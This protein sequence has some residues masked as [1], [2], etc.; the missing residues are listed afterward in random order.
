MSSSLGSLIPL[1]Q[2]ADKSSKKDDLTGG[3]ISIGTK[4]TSGDDNMDDFDLD[5][6]LSDTPRP[7][8]SPKK[9]KKAKDK[10]KKKKKDKGNDLDESTS[11]GKPPK[12]T[13]THDDDI[14]RP[15]KPKTSMKNLDDEFAK[16]LGFDASE[17]QSSKMDSP[18]KQL[19]QE[20]KPPSPAPSS[21]PTET[22]AIAASFFDEPSDKNKDAG[23]GSW[24]GDRPKGRG[25][26][27]SNDDDVDPFAAKDVKSTSS[28]PFSNPLGRHRDETAATHRGGRANADDSKQPAMASPFARGAADR[29]D[30]DLFNEPPSQT[31]LDKPATNSPSVDDPFATTT[32]GGTG[33]SGRGRRGGADAAQPSAATAGDD[34]P[35]FPWMKAK[36]TLPTEVLDETP[37]QFPW[38]KKKVIEERDQVKPEKPPKPDPK[39]ESD[40]PEFP[41]VKKDRNSTTADTKS[42]EKKEG[43]KPADDDDLPAFPW[44]K[45]TQALANLPPRV[46]EPPPPEPVAAPP[47]L[48]PPKSS[49]EPPVAPPIP[50][51]PI[52]VAEQLASPALSVAKPDSPVRATLQVE[53]QDRSNS[54]LRQPSPVKEPS[55]QRP[56]TPTSKP[57]A[58]QAADSDQ[59]SVDATSSRNSPDKKP[60]SPPRPSIL[61][62]SAVD[63]KAK[64]SNSSPKRTSPSSRASFLNDDASIVPA[65]MTNQ[66]A[67]SQDM[68][69]SLTTQLTAANVAL[70]MLQ[71]DHATVTANLSA[72]SELAKTLTNDVAVLRQTEATLRDDL[73]R[74]GA[75]SAR[76]LEQLN[77]SI[78]DKQALSQE[79]AT[80]RVQAIEVGPLQALVKELQIENSSFRGTLS[81]TQASLAACQRDLVKEQSLHSQSVERFQRMQHEREQEALHQQRWLVEEQRH[82]EKDA[83]ERLLTQVRA[84]VSGLKVLQEN[85]VGGKSELEMRAMGETETRA[86]VLLDME[87]SCKA[88]M[89]R[90]QEECHRLQALL[91][92]MEGTMRTLRGEHL[93][94]KERLR[95]EQS[96]LDE[97]ALHFQSQ[98]TLLQERTDSNT[99]VVTQTLSAYIQDIRVAE[100][101]LHTRREQLVE[102]ER[103]LHFARAAFAAQQEE[104]LRDQRLTQE[105]LHMEKQRI[106]EKLHRVRQETAAFETLVRNH[107][108]EMEAL[109]AY[110]LQL[111]G[112]K[113]RLQAAA[114]RI[115]E[116]AQKVRAASEQSA[117]MEAQAKDAM[118]DAA[119]L[120]SQVQDE[121]HRVQKQ[122][123]Q[124]DE[125]ERR[126]HEEMRCF[127]ETNRRKQR[128]PAVVRP[129]PRLPRHH[130]DTPLVQPPPPVAM[131]ALAKPFPSPHSTETPSWRA[132][133]TGL[134][135]SFRQEM[136]TFWSRGN[137]VEV[138]DVRN[139]MLLS[140]RSAGA[141][142]SKQ[143]Q[144][145]RST[146]VSAPRTGLT[147]AFVL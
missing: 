106:D 78:A 29:V 97:L 12:A 102:E 59:P 2:K 105:K 57:A 72:E 117:A 77:A 111:E 120:V 82:A 145:T 83:L 27:T 131:S 44:V 76:R 16:A 69:A 146:P 35:T 55:P 19:Y 139:R 147:S 103:Q 5:D 93:E 34:T 80:L 142:P 135:P 20:E 123:A 113:E 138:D 23:G 73:A 26:R 86:R 61:V 98:T 109:A 128:A 84:A 32:G 144:F 143:Q 50:V 87:G 95:A 43:S 14:P 136:E 89:H 126:L 90:S 30:D 56:S 31:Q 40:L 45:K 133:P 42:S 65:F 10:S 115:E 22:G 38:M 104:A 124:L 141:L 11:P 7:K 46:V 37:P 17:F 118:R 101:R 85:V 62:P 8:S 4:P 47:P 18:D 74:V 96:R 48:S 25:R 125:R 15:P 88:F 92:A 129:M 79:L 127:M 67:Q 64:P 36:S 107:S 94:E 58:T 9:P 13:F 100:A 66:L 6:L 91:S 130:V 112:E 54:P 140:C 137:Q 63:E 41:W 33:R 3:L 75:E 122:A 28:D 119:T 108:D 116:M 21:P 1:G 71:S 99:R 134:S 24:R 49:I 81:T 51:E 52:L 110:Q 121:R 70:A 60:A 68:V 114:S 53:I 132:D 39:V